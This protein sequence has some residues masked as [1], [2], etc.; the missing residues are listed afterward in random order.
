[1][2]KFLEQEGIDSKESSEGWIKRRQEIINHNVGNVRKEVSIELERNILSSLFTSFNIEPSD[3][4][5][6]GL[7]KSYVWNKELLANEEFKLVVI[8]NWFYPIILILLIFGVLFFSKRFVSNDIILKKNVSFVKTKGGQFALKVIVRVKSKRFVERIKVI[9]KL[10]HLVKLYEKFGAISPSEIDLKNR[11][12]EWNIES[13][14]AGEER[15]FSYI[16]YSKVGVIGRFELP[17]AR[18]IYEK[19]GRVK[20]VNSNRCF[21]INEPS[22]G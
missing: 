11:R 6:K 21:F 12:L 1:M 17:S 9:D 13:L 15:V 14:N 3:S 2:I 7:K 20:E 19:E 18:S 5:F 16:I 4:S 8:T 10:P 22:H